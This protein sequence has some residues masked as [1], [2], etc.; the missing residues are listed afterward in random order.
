MQ[1]ETVDQHKS[2]NL[3]DNN[4]NIPLCNLESLPAGP[5]L[6]KK[7]NKICF[8]YDD[9]LE[10]LSSSRNAPAPSLNGIT[11]KVHKKSP[12]ISRFLFRIFQAC[13]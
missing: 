2:S 10:I 6:L 9:F 1:E 3:F 5:L 13:F 11:Y 12:K 7:F 8:N 4:Y